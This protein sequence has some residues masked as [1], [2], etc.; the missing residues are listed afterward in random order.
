MTN[1]AT[2]T[3]RLSGRIRYSS[4]YEHEVGAAP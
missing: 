4:D 3:E 1:Y 2:F